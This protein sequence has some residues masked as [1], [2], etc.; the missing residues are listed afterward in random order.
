MERMTPDAFSAAAP[1][2]DHPA[3]AALAERLGARALALT[4]VS[5][6][7]LSTSLRRIVLGAPELTDFPFDPGQDLMLTVALEADGSPMRRRYT[8]RALD[9]AAAT[10]TVDVVVHGHGPGARWADAAA[11]GDL[12]GAI[13]PRGKITVEA[14][15]AWHLFVGDES[16]LPG[17]SIMAEALGPDDHA[18]LVVEVGGDDD[19]IESDTVAST[20]G[21]WLVRGADVEPG[22]DTLL[23]PAVDAVELPDGRGHVYLGGELR[24]VANLRDRLVARGLAPEQTSPKPYWRRGVGNA[25]HGEPARD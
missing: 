24:V 16:F 9:A 15:A 11:P 21:S 2:P 5:S 19:A 20:A 23:G 7:R 22:T 4:V 18:I 6:E 12:I 8:I 10:V 13:G 14:G 1:R 3:D 25:P 17:A